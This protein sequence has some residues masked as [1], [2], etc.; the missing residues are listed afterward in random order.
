MKIIV[1]KWKR[2]DRFE[3]NQKYEIF[4]ILIKL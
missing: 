2:R 4:I 1:K 3:I